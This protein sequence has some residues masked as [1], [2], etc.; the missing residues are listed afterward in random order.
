MYKS[1]F[2]A[3]LSVVIPSAVFC[4]NLDTQET[5]IKKI[6]NVL[7]YAKT[8]PAYAGKKFVAGYQSHTIGDHYLAGQRDLGRRLAKIPYD[9]TNKT[10]LDIGTNQGGMLLEL[11]DKIMCGVGI[12]YDAKLINAANRLKSCVH[13]N[14]I[15]FYIFDL[16]KEPLPHIN[17]FLKSDHVDICFFLSM[18][19]WVKNW[20][21]VVEY[22]YKVAD[23]LLFETN[24]S[25]ELER[26]E[27]AL[28]HQ[29]YRRV[30]LVSET[31]EDDKIQKKRKM[32]LCHKN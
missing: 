17:N 25:D 2:V 19:C 1:G 12:D 26:E 24:G 11:A 23:S 21:Q 29:K 30:I 13:A 27:I 22:A 20:K 7:S 3:L 4:T 15:D 5:E 16:D 9:F 14:N 10:V 28:I 18:C 32:F 31:S 6:C 8:H